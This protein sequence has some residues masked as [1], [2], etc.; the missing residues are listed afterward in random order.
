MRIDAHQHF[1]QLERGG[2]DWLTPDMAPIYRDFGWVDIEALLDARGISGTVAV[3]AQAYEA[4]TRYLLRMADAHPRIMGVVG[5][6]DFERPDAPFRIEALAGD[7]RLKGFR[8]MLQ[9]IAETEW[10]RWQQHRPSL[11]AME[12]HGLRFDALI[13]PR[14]LPVMLELAQDYPGLPVVIDHAAKPDLRGDTTIWA[15]DM[16]R[17]ARET[18]YFCKLSGL[19][20]EA[21]PGW[22]VETLRP[23]FDVLLDAFGPARLMWGSDW[24]VV[25]LNGD[26]DAWWR[27]TVALIDPLD[28]YERAAIL[29]GT[30]ARFYNL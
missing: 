1:W 3:Q 4:E 25:N 13:Q 7:R 16:R 17:I 28:K 5:W 10:I 18:P 30:A 11:M 8:P 24:P 22:T 15:N 6:V 12:R 20:T 26:Y 21:A 9:D 29:G 14:H 2:Y 19:V 27:A 23:V